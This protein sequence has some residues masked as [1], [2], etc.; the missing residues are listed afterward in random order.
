MM[1]SLL[2]LGLLGC[3]GFDA[4]LNVDFAGASTATFKSNVVHGAMNAAVDS[5]G[6][7][8]SVEV[9]PPPDAK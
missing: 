6:V 5:S 4:N 8:A 2:L 1:R 9:T 7:E 3:S